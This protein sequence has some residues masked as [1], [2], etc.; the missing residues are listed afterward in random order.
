MVNDFVTDVVFVVIGKLVAGDN[1]A[2]SVLVWIDCAVMET[3][4][5]T[6]RSEPGAVRLD[7]RGDGAPASPNSMR[8]VTVE[9]VVLLLTAVIGEGGHMLLGLPVPETAGSVATFGQVAAIEPLEV[10]LVARGP[11]GWSAGGVWSSLED[12]ALMVSV[13]LSV[14]EATLTSMVVMIA[15]GAPA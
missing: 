5:K 11:A 9:L 14:G 10:S 3:P 1:G 12:V 7:V 8:E 6:N 2:F 4:V 15:S 13:V